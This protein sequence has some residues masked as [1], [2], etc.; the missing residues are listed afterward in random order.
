MNEVKPD[1][2]KGQV[3]HPKNIAGRL[4]IIMTDDIEGYFGVRAFGEPPVFMTQEKIHE[5]Y[6]HGSIRDE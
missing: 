5:I 6:N 1:I 2:Q 3:W 4:V